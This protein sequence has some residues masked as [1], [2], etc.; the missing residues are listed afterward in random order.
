[1]KE[2]IFTER[3]G[4]HIIDLDRTRQEI[5]RVLGAVKQMAAEGKTILFVTTKPQAQEILKQAAQ[6]CGMPFLTDR[7]L[8]GLLTNFP[9]MKRML[10]K[11]RK[12]KEEQ[13]SG[14]L[15][16][17]TKKEQTKIGKD[18]VKM[19]MNLSGLATLM[20]MPDAIFVAAAQR[21]KTA[22]TEANRMNVPV[23]GICDTNS[24]PDRVE[25]VIPGN[26][27][28]VKSIT[29]LVNLVAEAIK[30][31]RAELEAAKLAQ[32]AMKKDVV[33]AVAGAE[34]K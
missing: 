3:H 16:K 34:S 32:A 20:D 13:A 18:L 10:N 28:A 27:D 31:G 19:D 15:E 29:L 26:D 2:Y 23:I 12:L 11:Y 1:M 6:S 22:L 30:E 17:Y 14:E 24:N 33:K 4:V 8:G 9:E 5:D 7:W 25:Y 21:E